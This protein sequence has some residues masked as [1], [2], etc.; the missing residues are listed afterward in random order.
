MAEHQ[1]E[2]TALKD[3]KLPDNWRTLGHRD[4]HMTPSERRTAGRR[5]W[6]VRMA[7]K[8]VVPQ[9]GEVRCRACLIAAFLPE[10]FP[11]AQA[12]TQWEYRER[13]DLLEQHWPKKQRQQV[14]VKVPG[15]TRWLKVL[16]RARNRRAA[17]TLLEE[18][19][20]EGGEIRKE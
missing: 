9:Q 17:E 2:E 20:P 12:V 15:C 18:L 16:V 7:M 14:E 8:G 10:L 1:K 11:S 5:A 13:W 4:K 3:A 6:F 19:L